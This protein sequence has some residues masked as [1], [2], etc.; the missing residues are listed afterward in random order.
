MSGIVTRTRPTNIG[1]EVGDDVDPA[2]VQRGEDRVPLGF[3]EL[4]APPGAL[5]DRR[6]DL[7]VVAGERAGSG[8][9]NEKG[10]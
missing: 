5:G 9:W 2:G 8:S 6:H 4:E 3:D 7:D 10:G 1:H